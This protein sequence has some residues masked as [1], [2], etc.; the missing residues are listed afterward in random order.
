MNRAYMSTNFNTLAAYE[1]MVST[2]LSDAQAK[3]LVKTIV[4]A[5]YELATKQDL[6]DVKSELLQNISNV[7]SELKQYISNLGWQ[8][9]GILAMQALSISGIG[10]LLANHFK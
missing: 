1:A 8:I 10:F 9:K 6:F 2:G 3:Q 5:Q 4:D 7:K